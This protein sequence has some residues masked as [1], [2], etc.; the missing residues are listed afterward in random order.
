ML[1]GLVGCESD[2]RKLQRL[3]LNMTVAC[4]EAEQAPEGQIAD[5]SEVEAAQMDSVIAANKVGEHS[6]EL[7][8]KCE[9]AT[10]EYNRFM[11]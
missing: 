7:Q 11:R 6:L 4:F 10:R 1:I 8:R 2:D 3:K 9:L 5:T